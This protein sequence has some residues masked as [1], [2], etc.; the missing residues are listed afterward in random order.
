V[1]IRMRGSG[2][3][4]S[5]FESMRGRWKWLAINGTAGPALGVS[6]FQWALATTPTGIVLPIVALTPLAIIPFSMRFEGEK[7]SLR[8]LAGA[9][10]AVIGVVGLRI[11]TH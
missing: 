1:W 5:F 2:P 8:S 6:C 10:I 3:K 7:P 4:K 9:V 11:T